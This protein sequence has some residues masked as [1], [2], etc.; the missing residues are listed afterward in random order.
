LI[1]VSRCS[2]HIPHGSSKYVWS[3]T[4]LL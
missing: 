1:T 2:L 3:L 4:S